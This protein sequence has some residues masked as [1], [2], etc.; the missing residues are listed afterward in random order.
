MT[1]ALAKIKQLSI[2]ASVL[3]LS[4]CASAPST[5]IFNTSSSKDY[6]NMYL[7][8][9]FN[10]WEAT[11]AFKLQAVSSNE[12]AVTIELIA[13]GQPY[14]FK[15]AD[16]TWSMPLNCGNSFNSN[17][18]TL[19]KTV[20]LVCASDS[21]NLKFTPKQTGLYTFTLDVSDNA[22]PELTIRAQQ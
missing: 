9:V 5:N 17:S 19:R 12:Y 6:S 16:S 8:G 4:A 11:D 21:V 3:V 1:Y 14:D 2:V 20:V 15:V 18:I 10:W 13:D 22:Q 7:R